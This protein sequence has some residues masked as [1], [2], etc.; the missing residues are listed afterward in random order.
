[1]STKKYAILSTKKALTTAIAALARSGPA[2]LDFETTSLYPKHGKVR[3]VTLANKSRRYLV[4]FNRIRGGFKACAHL[5]EARGIWVVFNAGFE[6]SWFHDAG[7]APVIWDVAYIR[8]AILGGGSYSLK[9]LVLWDLDIEMNK[10]EQRSDW[11]VKKLTK[12][13]LD[14]AMDDSVHTWSLYEHWS[15]QCDEGRWRAFHMIN[16]MVPAV[17]EMQ[18]NGMLLDADRHDKLVAKWVVVQQEKIKLIRTL[19]GD[20]EVAN[21]NSDMQW[22]NYF[23]TNMP[24]TFLGGWPRTEKTGQLSMKSEVLRM[25]AGTVPDTPLETFFDGLADY[26]KISKYISSFGY[27]LSTM[28]RLADDGRIHARYNIGAA[29]TV[30]FSCSGPNLQQTPRDNELLGEETSVRTSFVAQIVEERKRQIAR[31]LASLDYSGI[32]MRML[33]LLADD[34]QLMDDILN[35]DVHSEVAAVIAGKPIDR[36]TT[37]GKRLRQAAKGV[38]FGIIYGAGA[39]GLASTMRTSVGKASGYIDFWADRY[40]RAFDY[41]NIMMAEAQASRY[42]RVVDGGTIYMGKNPEMPKCANYPV[43]RAALSCIAFAITRHKNTLDE[44]RA[45]G[46]LKGTLFLSNIHDALI[47]ETEKR[48]APRVLRLMDADMTAGYLDVFPD[49]PIDK[50]VEGGYGPS[51]GELE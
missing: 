1:M 38:S 51:W 24:D 18:T 10:E 3:L 30:R 45:A 8:K 7:T 36:S 17:M 19:V 29:K 16:N 2:A 35:G 44:Q 26:K 31:V 15:A 37:A 43:Q 42:I 23:A 50:L 25:L 49:A 48:D 6:L 41:R 46:K 22:S 11:S 34:P 28:A 14:Y 13:Q 40:P 39:S 5:F 20:D 32:E 33:A 47:D 27:N 21:I 9:Q 4:D 12:S